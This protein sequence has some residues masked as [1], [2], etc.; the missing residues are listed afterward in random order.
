M[1]YSGMTLNERLVISGLLNEFE[2]AIKLKKRE[3][4]IRVL[5][6]LDIDKKGV[7]AILEKCGFELDE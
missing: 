6:Q 3:K 7:N 5:Q 1:D 4:V 2:Q